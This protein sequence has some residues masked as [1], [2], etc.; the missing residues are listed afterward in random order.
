MLMRYTMLLTP[1]CR[2]FATPFCHDFVDAMLLIT[3]SPVF[4]FFV[5]DISL[6]LPLRRYLPCL[7]LLLLRYYLLRYYTRHAMLMLA[8]A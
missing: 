3:L 8:A 1:C 4:F 7:P 6:L 2:F 5:I